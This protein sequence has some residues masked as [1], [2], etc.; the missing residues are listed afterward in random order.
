[1]RRAWLIML[2]AAWPSPATAQRPWP[3][4]RLENLEVLPDTMP[5]RELVTLMAGFTRALGVRCTHCHV[6]E[7]SQ[8]LSAYDFPSDEKPAKRKA[9]EMLRMVRAI[10]GQY[11]RGLETRQDPPVEVQC[12]TCH[13]G[14]TAPRT[15]QETLLLAYRA[16]GL[17]STFATYATL[18]RQYFGGA[19]YDFG[20]VALADVAAAVTRS[21]NAG[22]AERLYAANV[23]HNPQ[24]RFAQRQHGRFAVERAFADSGPA[25]GTARYGAL[26][27]VYG[28]EAFPEGLM[29]ELGY[30]LL[31]RAKRAEAVAAFTL[32]VDAFPRSANAQDSLG[33]AYAAAGDTA[34]AIAS[35]E[36]SLELDPDNANAARKL[37]AL[38]G[39]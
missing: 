10:N 4:E 22:D 6:G 32:N 31:R 12:I 37:E 15:L 35:Y 28:Q 23:E 19:A 18:R 8:P 2:A 5:V 24:S 25:A 16:G 9:R 30:A 17:D 13:R 14:I 36:R 1:M 27:T 20:E 39:R 21:G 34:R 29:N 26:R 33:E 38:R 3:P 7:E 11:L